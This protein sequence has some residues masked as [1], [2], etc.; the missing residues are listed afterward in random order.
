MSEVIV[1]VLGLNRGIR[2]WIVSFASDI[3]EWTDALE[4]GDY[5]KVSKWHTRLGVVHTLQLDGVENEGAMA[6]VA[7]MTIVRWIW[8]EAKADGLA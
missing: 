5:V 4:V 2:N 3:L 6:C 7:D 8:S 1:P